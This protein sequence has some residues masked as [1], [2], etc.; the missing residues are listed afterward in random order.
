MLLSCIS[1]VG[2]AL[3]VKLRTGAAAV[4]T[5]AAVVGTG[6]GAEERARA[7]VAG[8]RAAGAEVAGTRAGA[9]AGAVGAGG[10]PSETPLLA[11]SLRQVHSISVS[12]IWRGRDRLGKLIRESAK[13]KFL[14]RSPGRGC[15]SAR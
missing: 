2:E 13:H 14:T 3:G 4:D 15:P 11:R 8:V 7:G 1:E 10:S 6:A 5:I 9:G 12:P